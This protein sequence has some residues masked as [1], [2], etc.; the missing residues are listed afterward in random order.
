MFPRAAEANGCGGEELMARLLK[1]YDGYRFSEAETHVCNP[2]S[3]SK[4][5]GQGY[6]LS[7]YW[8]DTGTPS[9]LLALARDREYDYEAALEAWYDESVFSAYELDRLDV[10][11]LLWQTGY[12][13]IRDARRGRRGLQYRLGFPDMEVQDTFSMRLLEYYGK[14]AKGSGGIVDSLAE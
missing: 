11:G 10:T 8:D 5:F 9:F 4:F 13:T 2:V 7:N 14:V 3:V 12:L 6:R 1:W